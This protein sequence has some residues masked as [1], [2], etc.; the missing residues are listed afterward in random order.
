MTYRVH[1]IEF[2]ESPMGLLAKERAWY[3][4]F[5]QGA[6]WKP[7]GREAVLIAD[8]PAEWRLNCVRFLERRASR[9]ARVYARGCEAELWHALNILNGEMARDSIE[10]ALDDEA[11]Y[12]RTDPTEWITTTPLYLALA[13]G[14]PVKGKKLRRLE[15]RA[16]HWAGCEWRRG[17]TAAC[18]C[19]Q[20]R[21]EHIARKE[22]AHDA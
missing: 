7:D 19:E 15:E 11:D 9:Y 3:G 8:M 2:T 21:Q 16:A 13:T 1:L 17:N 14:L 12:A 18:S 4:Y 6:R 20:L 10:R 22:A 5:N